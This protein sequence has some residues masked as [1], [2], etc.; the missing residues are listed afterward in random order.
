MDQERTLPQMPRRPLLV[1]A[2]VLLVS[3]GAHGFDDKVTH[4]ELALKAVLASKLDATIKSTLS[5]T[6]GT[7]A[8]L[9]SGSGTRRSVLAWLQEGTTGED[10]GC[11]AKSH[12]H[13][14]WKDFAVSGVT[15]LDGGNLICRNRGFSN[16]TWGT[17]FTAPEQPGHDETPNLF[18]WS[19]ARA[20]YYNALTGG[21]AQEREAALADTFLKLGYVLHLVQDLAVPAHV[22]DDF[23]SHVDCNAKE[24]PLHCGNPFERY[25]RNT[26]GLLDEVMAS[27]PPVSVAFQDRYLTR[28]WDTGLLRTT[29]SPLVSLDQGLAEYTNVNFA[30]E[31]TILTE[32]KLPTERYFFRYPNSASTNLSDILSGR[33]EALKNCAPRR[34][35]QD[36]GWYLTKEGP[37]ERIEH[38]AKTGYLY[39]YLNQ[40]VFPPPL[41]ELKP[42]QLDQ[43]VYR[44]YALKVLPMAVAYTAGLLDYFFRGR[45]DFQLVEIEG[46]E[47]A[48]EDPLPPSLGL[49]IRNTGAEEM[50]GSFFLF[51]ETAAGGRTLLITVS[52]YRP[53]QVD[54]PPIPFLTM[55]PAD[56]TRLV[57]AFRGTLGAEQDTEARVGGVAGKVK[58]WTAPYVRIRQERTE[59][60]AE[61]RLVD[62]PI[63][64]V[65]YNPDPWQERTKDARTQRA[66]GRFELPDGTAP[67]KAMKRIW[68]EGGGEGVR[69]R[70]DEQ[71]VGALEW[72][73]E[74]AAIQEPSRWEI[75]IDLPALGTVFG[76]DENHL[77]LY[78]WH[79]P[80][81]LGVETAA[82]MSIRMPLVWWKS[83]RTQSAAHRGGEVA[84]CPPDNHEE[85]HQ[86]LDTS[87]LMTGALFYGDGNRDGRDVRST[88]TTESLYPVTG[89]KPT[90]VRFVPTGEVD[91]YAIG[92]AA[93]GTVACYDRCGP[94]GSCTATTVRVFQEPGTDGPLW[95]KAAFL[96]SV[97]QRDVTAGL[98]SFCPIPDRPM[99]EA[100]ALPTIT[101]Q[102]D[103]RPRELALFQQLGITPTPYTIELR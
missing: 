28:F 98:G 52:N 13:N 15:D 54:T 10:A 36:T 18:T 103:Y 95:D 79:L 39:N 70:L 46:P 91:G 27:A 19:Y 73:Q 24:N 85:C 7:E 68:V 41:P 51:A 76:Y 33:A 75:A 77:P 2:L 17:D 40:T 55:P 82:G 1:A 42:Y 25:V 56:T 37:G 101:L 96:A 11:R 60:T 59:L 45:L 8:Q 65:P 5:L 32:T 92:A 47:T 16:V 58:E 62:H 48:P 44:D 23:Q 50:D 71:E 74:E 29:Q 88:G 38:F 66:F 3:T 89:T 57:L 43:C 80:R 90:G 99:P 69:L 102:R 12:F 67:G 49:V 64:S 20:A 4:P 21:T 34:D 14:P 72:T 26:P 100:A 87:T 86:L 97:T 6:D 63:S 78:T 83:V 30:S 9:R 61:E 31:N 94:A 84:A 93:S 35:V 81:Y 22:R 53:A